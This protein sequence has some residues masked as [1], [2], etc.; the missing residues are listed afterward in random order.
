MS[1]SQGQQAN[2]AQI[3]LNQGLAI[4]STA[5]PALN[6]TYLVNDLAGEGIQAEVNALWISNSETFADGTASL[7]WPDR[8]GTGHT[9]TVAQFKTFANACAL[10]VA[11]CVQYSAGLTT[12]APA[13][14]ATIP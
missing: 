14:T 1:A 10:F 13:N 3:L 12:T 2:Q 7:D 8:A 4:T 5:T 11:Q 6:G 9:F